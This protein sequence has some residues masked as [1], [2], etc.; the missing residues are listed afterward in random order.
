[1]LIWAQRDWQRAASRGGRNTS[2]WAPTT[3]IR[4]ARR[5]PARCWRV[6]SAST[7]C[8]PSSSR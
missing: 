2:T 1:M 5:K 8:R 3:P 4:T 7:C 6:N